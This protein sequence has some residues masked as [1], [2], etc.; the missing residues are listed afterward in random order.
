[1]GTQGKKAAPAGP[2]SAA[3]T[4]RK[5]RSLTM[6]PSASVSRL[7][8]AAV[9]FLCL[10]GFYWKL[11]LSNQFDWMSGPDFAEQVLPK[12]RPLFSEWDDKWWPEPMRDDERAAP[13]Q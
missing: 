10:A 3:S 6:T 2:T 9:L 11:T 5:L 4:N 1:M 12:L 8:I 13:G 7:R